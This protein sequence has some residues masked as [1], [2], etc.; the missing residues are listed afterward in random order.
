MSR[1]TI[2][3]DLS[4]VRSHCYNARRIAHLELS[5]VNGMANRAWMQNPT[6]WLAVVLYAGAM[7]TRLL[8]FDHFL[9]AQEYTDESSYY[10]LVQNQIGYEG[11]GY[12]PPGRYSTWSPGYVYTSSLVLRI[13]DLFR[14][15]DWLLPSEHLLALRIVSVGLTAATLAFLYWA[16]WQL[17]GHPAGVLVLVVWGFQPYL[18]DIDTLGIPDVYAFM[19]TAAALAVSIKAWQDNNPRTLLVALLMGLGAVMTKASNSMAV[20]PFSV[21]ALVM[22][23]RHP[24]RMMGWMALYAGIALTSAYYLFFVVDPFANT[25]GHREMTTVATPVLAFEMMTDPWR[26]WRNARFA[27]YPIGVWP[28]VLGLVAGLPAYFYVCR[29]EPAPSWPGVMAMIGTFFVAAMLLAST[30]TV[31]RL[32]SGKLRHVFSGG[33]GMTLL[34]VVGVSS[35]MVLVARR[36]QRENT[37]TAVLLT[38]VAVGYLSVNMPQNLHLIGEYR[39]TYYNEIVWDYTDSSLP[40]EGLVW[41]DYRSFLSSMWNRP[42]GGYDGSRPFEWWNEPAEDLI[43]QTPQELRERNITHLILSNRDVRMTEDPN[44][45]RDY[46]DGLLML[47]SFEIDD[48]V[49]LYHTEMLDDVNVIQVY[50]VLRPQHET[51]VRFGDAIHMIGYDLPQGTFAAGDTVPLRFFWSAIAQP[52]D[53]YSTFVHLYPAGETETLAQADGPPALRPTVTWDDPNEILVGEQMRLLL[54]ADLGAGEYRLA[55]GL[56]RF[57]DGVRLA[58]PGGTTFYEI[59]VTVE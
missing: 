35:L 56:Y 14:S 3:N 17:G 36:F 26:V 48:P 50:R 4:L 15:T 59:P 13:A 45:F 6:V 32:A 57:T 54:P 43:A 24:R 52:A 46:L 19:F 29:Q 12:L 37:V 38:L 5:Q 10:I 33:M 40:K 16:A 55:V 9:P 44:A 25:E 18:I 31:A 28:L 49:E 21:T 7:V 47:K 11:A 2:P 1:S 20:V 22:F 42:W 51:D 58:L 8:L 41:F 27:V 34:W 23:V 30:F 39:Q 53:N